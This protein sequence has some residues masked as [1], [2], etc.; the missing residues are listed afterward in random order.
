MRSRPDDYPEEEQEELEEPSPRRMFADWGYRVLLAAVVLAVV[1]V[2]ALPYLLDWWNPPA[3]PPPAPI[4]SQIPPPPPLTPPAQKVE[5]PKPP[6]APPAA[7]PK[8]APVEAPPIA[9]GPPKV[10][11][12]APEK[13]PA[14][15]GK[16]ATPPATAKAP[17]KGQYW[18][19]VGAFKDQ[20][21]AARLAAR[22]TTQKYP[23]RQT[24]RA[25][26]EGSA[27]GTHEVFVVGASRDE[28][29]GK[30]PGKEYQAEAVG[31]EVV[32][33][34]ALGLK[35]AV[36]LSKELAGHGFKV[37]IRRSGSPATFHVVRVGG[38]PDRQRA[39]RVQKDLAAKGFAGF[40]VK[41]EGQ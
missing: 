30:L 4:T 37:R 19:Q 36:S 15:A 13:P 29:T 11:A 25:A 8:P 27:G 1:V 39:Q 34:P 24:E 38:Y 22:L 20:A 14:S 41:G 17:S 18:I 6:P 12:K 7:Q 5:A 2:L 28:V 9:A 35:D 40:V 32:V 10:A 31:A 16:P 3:P 26:A 21:N 33:R 23:V